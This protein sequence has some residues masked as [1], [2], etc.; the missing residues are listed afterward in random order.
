MAGTRGTRRAG[1]DL[2][3]TDFLWNI[4]RYQQNFPAFFRRIV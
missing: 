3:L 4:I 2:N 1:F